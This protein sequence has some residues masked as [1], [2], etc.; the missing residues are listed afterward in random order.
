MSNI[1]CLS[2]RV[3]DA[4]MQTEADD[5]VARFQE[6]IQFDSE[7]SRYAL[8]F[9]RSGVALHPMA[10][11]QH[12]KVQVDFIKGKANHRR[13]FGGGKNQLISKAVGLSVKKDLF[14]CDA[15]AGL[16]GDAFVLASLGA[17][18]DL[19]E[20]SPIAF[21]LLE[22]GL[23]RASIYD[24]TGLAEAESLGEIFLRMHLIYADNHIW[25]SECDDEHYDVLYFDPM[26]PERAKKKSAVKK[27]MQ[28][29]QFLIAHQEEDASLLDLALNA[30]KYRV[31]VK[32]PIRANAYA[33]CTPSYSLSGK[34]CRF[35]IYTKK[36]LSA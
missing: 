33:E 20:N 13:L 24:E 36:T 12:G 6:K 30:V 31:V 29:F 9:S 28:A 2:I 3:L 21:T 15:T 8:C 1:P 26:F 35:D 22:D 17:K 32:R 14:V 4:S 19:I 23:K 27:E 10:V 5:F 11:G 25:L 18:V 16:G 7:S 34:S